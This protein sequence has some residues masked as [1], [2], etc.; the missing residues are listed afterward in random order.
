[1]AE[2]TAASGA[3][4]PMLLMPASVV[5]SGVPILVADAS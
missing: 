3:L 1:L 2:P 4:R 5:F